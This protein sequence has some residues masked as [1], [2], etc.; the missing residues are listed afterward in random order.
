MPKNRFEFTL[1]RVANRGQHLNIREMRRSPFRVAPTP[2]EGQCRR[3]HPFRTLYGKQLAKPDVISSGVA[4][5][6]T[7]VKRPIEQPRLEVQ[8]RLMKLVACRGSA[9]AN[10]E[11]NAA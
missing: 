6:V 11:W 9:N 7:Q 8:K 5:P 1:E 4:V 3:R 10:G 2:Q